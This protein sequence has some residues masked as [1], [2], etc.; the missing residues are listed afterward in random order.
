MDTCK[1]K[2]DWRQVKQNYNRY[3]SEHHSEKLEITNQKNC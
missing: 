2:E 1:G 3:S